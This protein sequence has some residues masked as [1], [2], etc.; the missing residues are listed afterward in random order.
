MTKLKVYNG[1]C[2]I[3]GNRKL[4]ENVEVTAVDNNRQ[5]VEIYKDLFPQD[6]VI[7]GDSHIYLLNH[8][9]EFDFIWISPPCPSHSQFRQRC[10][11][12][13]WGYEP[14][15]PDM[16]LYEEIIFLQYH[17]KGKWVVENVVSYYEPLIKPAE[18]S[19]HYFWANF[20]ISSREKHQDLP[21]KG[22]EI[23]EL[24]ELYGIDLSKYKLKNKRQIL[25]NC[26]EPEL[27][28]H[29]LNESFVDIQPELFGREG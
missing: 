3:G 16:R 12:K 29:I 27:G 10:G 6:K 26:V 25:R 20:H 8:F 15:Y 14:V 7:H 17:S 28:L 4:W 13:A 21:I 19:R 18:I 9:Q 5:I 24:Q 2:G 1:Y 11:V 23:K 22:S